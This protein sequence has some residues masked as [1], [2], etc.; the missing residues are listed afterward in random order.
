MEGSF[1]IAGIE[2]AVQQ[3]L[4]LFAMVASLGKKLSYPT[5]LQAGRKSRTE[6]R[7][8]DINCELIALNLILVIWC[9]ENYIIHDAPL[10]HCTT[11]MPGYRLRWLYAFLGAGQL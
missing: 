5:L 10:S 3:H 2:K 1:G 8:T 4:N 6:I 7:Q 9:Q 11:C